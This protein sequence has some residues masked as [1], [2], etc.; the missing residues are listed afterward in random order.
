MANPPIMPDAGAGTTPRDFPTTNP[1]HT[2]AGDH[3]FLLQAIM[4]NQRT[5]GEVSVK[6]D[7]I[8][9]T[10]EGHDKKIDRYGITIAFATGAILILGTIGAYVLDKIWNKLIAALG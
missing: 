1:S 2:G 4:E 10:L 7:S 8:S 6:V 3:S 9:S 5:L